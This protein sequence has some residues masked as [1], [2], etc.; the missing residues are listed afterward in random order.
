MDLKLYDLKKK[1]RPRKWAY[2]YTIFVYL[3]ILSNKEERKRNPLT[4]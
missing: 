4:L 1:F 2:T 3:F